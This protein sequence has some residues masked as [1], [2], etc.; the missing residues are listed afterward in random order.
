M[1]AAAASRTPSIR[2]RVRPSRT[3][4]SPSRSCIASACTPTRLSTAL[5][6]LGPDD[7]M[8]H[9]LRIGLAARFVSAG[10]DGL[11]E[12]LTPRFAAML[13]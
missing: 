2:A 4:S 1:R 5:T 3:A 9:A 11:R 13:A 12:R 7:G 8:A 6:V 10:P